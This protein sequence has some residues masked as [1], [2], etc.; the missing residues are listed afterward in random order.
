MAGVVVA[1]VMTAIMAA[2]VLLRDIMKV[3]TCSGLTDAPIPQP[4]RQLTTMSAAYAPATMPGS[5]KPA[6]SFQN[7]QVPMGGA[8]KQQQPTMGLQHMQQPM[9][10]QPPMMGPGMGYPGQMPMYG[11]QMGQPRY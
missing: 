11:G 9:M 8:P 7:V 6:P 3:W 4:D 5:E 2:T 10:G 1:I